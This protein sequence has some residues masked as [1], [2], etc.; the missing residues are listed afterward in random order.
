MNL[1]FGGSLDTNLSLWNKLLTKPD[2][3]LL[4]MNKGS[5]LYHNLLI[6]LAGRSGIE[7]A[8]NGLKVHARYPALNWPTSIPIEDLW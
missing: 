6:L 1:P 7:P 8:T 4:E 3:R 2:L 5:L